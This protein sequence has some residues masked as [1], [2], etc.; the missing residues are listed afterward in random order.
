MIDLVAFD[1]EDRCLRGRIEL[2]ADRLADALAAGGALA[3]KDAQVIDLHSD[4]RE[5]HAHLLVDAR[6]LSIVVATGPRG[7]WRRRVPVVTCP[8]QLYVGRY[9]LHG[10]LHAARSQDPVTNA[11]TRPWLAMTE[12]IL[13]HN[14]AGRIIR[15]RYEVLLINRAHAKAIVR[16][17]EDAHESHWLAATPAS[18]PGRVLRRA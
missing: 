7:S 6:T 8:A 5:L 1:A 4:R 17:S 11:A 9:M 12:A 15:E 3:V 13:E 14:E 2:S 10:I 18:G 16:T